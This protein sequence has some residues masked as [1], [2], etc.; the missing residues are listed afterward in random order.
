MVC[1]RAIATSSMLGEKLVEVKVRRRGGHTGAICFAEDP[2]A[3]AQ[4]PGPTSA[5]PPAH[6]G[7]GPGTMPA[8]TSAPSQQRAGHALGRRFHPEVAWARLGLL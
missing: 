4:L 7:G 2:A 1:T 3:F 6:P 8:G 5:V